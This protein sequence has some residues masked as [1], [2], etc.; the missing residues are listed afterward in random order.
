SMVGIIGVTGVTAESWKTLQAR[1]QESSLEAEYCNHKNLGRGYY[2]RVARAI[3]A[4]RIF[5]VGLNNWSYWVSQKY[6]PRL[7]YRFVPYKGTDI[8]PSEVIP[9][10]SNVDEAQAAPAHCLL[11]LML[12]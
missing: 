2:I 3:A 12:G 8:E 11:A 7:G 9:E 5:G 6:G 1:F 10:N 4:D